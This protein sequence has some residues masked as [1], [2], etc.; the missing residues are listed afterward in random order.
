MSQFDLIV[1]GTGAGLEVSSAAAAEGWQVA[2]I[3]EGPF[4]GVCLNSGCIPSKLLIRSADVKD[5][6]DRAH[7]W[8]INAEVKNVN[9]GAI[10]EA[11]NHEVDSEAAQIEA[12][13]AEAE[14]ITVIR[15]RARFSGEKTLVVGE[16][17]VTAPYIVI[18]AGS[19]PRVPEIAG[20]A[21][22]PYLTSDDAMRLEQQPRK[23]AILGGG[24]VAAE[25]AHF[26]GT[27]G[28]DVTIV[29]RSGLLLRHEDDDISRTFTRE[30]QDRFEVCLDTAVREVEYEDGQF[31]LR[32]NHQG[33]AQPL[34]CDA[35]LIAA[36]R[37]PNTDT[38]EVSAA[39]V[40]TD[41]EGFVR[42]NKYLETTVPGI[43]ALGDIAGYYMLR[44]NSNLEASHV[45]NNLLNPE[46][47]IAVDHH[48]M[49]HAVFASPQVGSV[50]ITEAEAER[51][52]KP[53]LVGRAEYSDVTYG[54]ALRDESGFVKVIVDEESGEVLGC[55]IL[56][57]DAS[58]L[59]Q[60]AAL[61]IRHHLP[62]DA[63]TS[64]V[65]I[66]PALPEVV[67]RAFSAVHS[68]AH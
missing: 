39:G 37:V 1:I 51:R 44:H 27:L 13:N 9:W 33:E 10:I 67:Q 32:L 24:F 59:V 17:E 14:N 2:V 52:G 26:F 65:Y 5:L 60:E 63:I 16:T 53:Y 47:R 50:G 55:H 35:L 28:T 4:G 58:I 20:L 68:H 46:K 57:T 15:G 29:Q 6:V 54:M 64:S 11:V 43:W 56:G 48:G 12:A 8:G 19:R 62:Y 49:P 30:L 3:E 38:L 40:E 7:L 22:A 61:L 41:D 36:G 34:T 42:T 23:M 18:A 25:L 31:R 45:A 66:H 21:E